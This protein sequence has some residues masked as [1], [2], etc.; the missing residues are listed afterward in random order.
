MLEQ[1]ILEAYADGSPIG[2]IMESFN[3]SREQITEILDA[4]LEANRY[5]RTFTDEFKRMIAERDINGIPR[6]QIALELKLNVNTIKK[7]CEQ[8]GQ[9]LKERATSDNAYI[10]VIRDFDLSTCPSC[11]SKKV[12]VVDENT[13]YC[14][15]CGNESVHNEDHALILKWEYID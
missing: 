1:K 7:A 14:K 4:H 12:N 11:E 8:F 15:S 13:T 5:K 6:R 9:A 3:V 2:L 10:T